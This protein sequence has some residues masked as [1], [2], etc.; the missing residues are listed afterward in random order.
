MRI[1]FFIAVLAVASAP[2]TAHEN[3]QVEEQDVYTLYRTSYIGGES[4]RIHVA[5]F[6]SRWGHESNK[7]AC[8]M[9][10]DLFK[11]RPDETA[12]FWCEAGYVKFER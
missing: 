3:A 8:E 2:S 7:E 1:L 4:S 6:D 9:T 10:R 5:T 12:T 11:N